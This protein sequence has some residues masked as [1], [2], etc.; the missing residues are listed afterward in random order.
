MVRGRDH[1]F[2]LFSHAQGSFSFGHLLSTLFTCKSVHKASAFSPSIDP[3]QYQAFLRL[4]TIPPATKQASNFIPNFAILS[5]RVWYQARMQFVFLVEVRVQSLCGR[6]NM[7]T[8]MHD[9]LRVS[10]ATMM[11][12][13]TLDVAF[14]FLGEAGVV[15]GT[16]STAGQA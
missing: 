1:G 15:A 3:Y 4:I 2:D 13:R 5:W 6:S 14:C 10:V 16:G 7:R 8:G 11:F 9:V 12:L